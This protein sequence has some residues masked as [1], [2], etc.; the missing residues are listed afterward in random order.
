MAMKL[1]EGIQILTNL[2]WK[3]GE[4]SLTVNPTEV[5]ITEGAL[6]PLCVC[7]VPER[8]NWARNVGSP[9]QGL[10]FLTELKKGGG[11]KEEGSQ[12]TT[13][14]SAS[15]LWTQHGYLAE[16]NATI[17]LTPPQLPW[18]DGLSVSPHTMRIKAKSSFLKFL[19]SQK[20]EKYIIQKIYFTSPEIQSDQS[21]QFLGWTGRRVKT[22]PERWAQV[23]CMRTS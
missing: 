1:W 6:L 8:T 15:W 9:S 20:Q 2:F 12:E 10:G 22:K 14:I 13:Q 7:H 16:H 3:E 18:Q 23:L 4:W 21:P 5:T 11:Q 19:R 17:Q